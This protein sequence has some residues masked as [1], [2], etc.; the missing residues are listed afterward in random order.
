MPDPDYV[1]DSEYVGDSEYAENEYD[2][3]DRDDLPPRYA[4]L[5][6]Y[7]QLLSLRDMN[8]SYELPPNLNVHPDHYLP[9]YNYQP[10]FDQDSILD[11]AQTEEDN[12][13][14][15]DEQNADADAANLSR[16]GATLRHMPGRVYLS[17]GYV[18]SGDYTTDVEPPSRTSFI[19]DM[20]MS[21][22]GYTSNASCSDISGL[23]EIEDS[24]VNA[25]EDDSGDDEHSP[26]LSYL[27]TQ[28]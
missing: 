1:E 19:D 24:E 26:C 4:D 16:N 13:N 14:V 5:P 23:C 10:Q 25:S 7:E 3:D 28:V 12:G 22:G 11:G 27:H 9:S 21:V 2:F 8:D 15:S 6:S 18:T 17:P 20:S